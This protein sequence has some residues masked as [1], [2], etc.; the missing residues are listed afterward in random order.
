MRRKMLLGSVSSVA[1]VVMVMCTA[2]AADWP[3][4]QG[5]N[6]DGR[7]LEKG[8]S[9]TWPESGPRVLWSVP[10][11]AGFAGPAIVDGEVYILDRVDDEKDVLR[12]L[13]L[14]TGKELWTYSYDSPGLVG[15]NGS[16]GTPTVDASYVYSVGMLGELTCV[17]RK[18]HKPV[19]RK[20]LL[21]DLDGEMSAHDFTLEDLA[22]KPLG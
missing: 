12:C 8:V 21:S 19:W 13:D 16:R 22:K 11:G 6:R 10:L 3:Q 18:T 17:D 15:H 20:N 9:R 14:T 7:S 5:V 4:F 2:P 1:A